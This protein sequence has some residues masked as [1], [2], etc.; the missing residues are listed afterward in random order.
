MTSALSIT[1][2]VAPPRAAFLDFP[3]GHTTGKKNQPEMQLSL[4]RQALAG[5]E[6]IDEPGAIRFLDERWS[7]DESWRQNAMAG[8]GSKEK[9]SSDDFRTPRVDTPQYQYSEDRD[10]AERLHNKG[11]CGSC[12]GAE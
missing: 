8:G 10:E 4:M 7:E 6:E 2:S 11:A 3:L 9:E 12:V 1:R 5:F